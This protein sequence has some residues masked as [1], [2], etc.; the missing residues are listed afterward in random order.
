[1]HGKTVIHIGPY[2]SKGGISS[3]MKSLTETQENIWNTKILTTHV[4]AGTI[5]QKYRIY[6][7][8]KKKLKKYINSNQIDIVH[9]HATQSASWWRKMSYLNICIQRKVP[10]IIHIHSGRFDEF[11]NK[12]G[13]LSGRMVRKY[14]FKRNVKTVLLEKRWLGK[15][16]KWIPANSVVI[17]NPYDIKI[18]KYYQKKNEI[19]ILMLARNSK[20]KGHNFAIEIIKFLIKLGIDVKLTLT[21]I[22]RRNISDDFDGKI[23]AKGWVNDNEI[24]QLM[25]DAD[26]L[27]SPSEFEGS[28]ISVINSIVSGLPCIVSPASSETIGI[29][30]LIVGLDDPKQWAE[31]IIKLSERE[32]YHKLLKKLK[33]ESFRYERAE[34]SKIWLKTYNEILNNSY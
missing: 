22:E 14:L 34:I 6:R 26:F 4:E 13:G 12:F 32:V 17:N 29:S 9:I 28:S 2:Q 23:I 31:R 25:K 8:A 27:I 24:K 11:C 19:N 3:V 16:N 18:K 21:G 5:I 7:S 1:M 15:L 20:G 33:K 10:A 30:E